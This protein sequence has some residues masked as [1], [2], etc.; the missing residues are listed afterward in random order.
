MGKKKENMYTIS[1]FLLFYAHVLS[2][3]SQFMLSVYLF[4]LSK[5]QI[6][7]NGVDFSFYDFLSSVLVETQFDERFSAT[8][9]KFMKK[10]SM[11]IFYFLLI[12]DFSL[13]NE[14]IFRWKMKIYTKVFPKININFTKFN[15]TL[16]KLQIF[17]VQSSLF[18]ENYC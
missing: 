3:L 11:E 12:N 14:P 18:I 5:L 13:E 4:A 16:N 10:K 7:Q 17:R 6:F 8:K 9:F 1:L 2:I 15:Q